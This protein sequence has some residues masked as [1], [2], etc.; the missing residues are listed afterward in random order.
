MDLAEG[1]YNQISKM[2]VQAIIQDEEKIYI[3]ILREE[4]RISINYSQIF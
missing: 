3:W 1:S 4:S 2:R